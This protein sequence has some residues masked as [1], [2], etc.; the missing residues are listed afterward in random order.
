MRAAYEALPEKTK[1]FVEDKVAL[2]S[3]IY[4]REVLGFT[5]YSP[6]ERDGLPPAR[7]AMVRTHPGSGR[8]ALDVASYGYEIEGM[9]TPQARILLHDLIERPPSGSSFTRTNGGLA[10]S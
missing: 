10:T 4:S 3:L 9:L 5:D 8:K 1:A 6:A 2:H 7:H